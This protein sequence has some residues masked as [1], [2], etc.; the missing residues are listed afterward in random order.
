MWLRDQLPLDL[1]GIRVIIYGYDTTLI[2]SHS[3]QDIDDIAVAFIRR[4]SSVR[5]AGLS[6]KPLVL[7][8]HSLGGI[9]LKSAMLRL[10]GS[11]EYHQSLLK[12]VKCAFFFG[13][14]S[15]GMHISHLMALVEDQPN[16]TLIRN[17]STGSDYLLNLGDKLSGIS[18]YRSIRLISAY[19]TETSATVVV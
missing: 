4:L 7:L 8:A 15:K 17:L 2:N 10:A 11:G 19:E 13:V 1:P 5:P 9:I 12:D 6:R 3:F 16:G 14:P 18:L